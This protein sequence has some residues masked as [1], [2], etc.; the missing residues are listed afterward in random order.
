MIRD[1]NSP[2]FPDALVVVGSFF[3]KVPALIETC[4]VDCLLEVVREALTSEW[5][6]SVR[7]SSIVLGHIF[8]TYRMNVFHVFGSFYEIIEDLIMNRSDLASSRWFLMRAVSRMVLG[9]TVDGDGFEVIGP[10]RDR[11][12][13]LMR[14]MLWEVKVALE[15]ELEERFSFFG[16]LIFGYFAYIEVFCSR[17]LECLKDAGVVQQE[18]DALSDISDMAGQM[19]NFSH[20]PDELL[21]AF[22]ELLVSCSRRCSRKHFFMLNHAHNLKILG[23]T[24]EGKRSEKIKIAGVQAIGKLCRK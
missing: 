20:V 18:K 12:F 4:E 15:L 9:I 22:I 14:A 19:L 16:A 23:L 24:Q 10:W 8:Q 6:D 7:S 13:R 11:F 1:K 5:Q 17:E 21:N 3:R 2:V